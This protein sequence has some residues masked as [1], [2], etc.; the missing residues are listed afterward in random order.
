MFQKI[1]VEK[2]KTSIFRQYI[3]FFN[4]AVYALVRTQRVEQSVPM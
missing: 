3:F 1:F 2:I 4:S